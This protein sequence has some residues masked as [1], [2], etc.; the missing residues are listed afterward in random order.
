MRKAYKLSSC[1]ILSDFMPEYL[2]KWLLR[3]LKKLWE[4]FKAEEFSFEDAQSA[5]KD[6]SRVV[7]IVLSNL[8]KYGWI[9]IKSDP[10]DSRKKLYS[11][12]HVDVIEKMKIIEISDNHA[13]I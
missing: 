10:S 8:D 12:K 7:A 6:D 11:L 4:N 5:L 3:R 9:N 13:K 2:P 1:I